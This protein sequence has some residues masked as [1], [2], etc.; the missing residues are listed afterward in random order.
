MFYIWKIMESLASTFIVMS[1]SYLASP[2]FA[3]YGAPTILAVLLPKLFM[4]SS[5]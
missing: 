1:D 2:V 4:A 3:Q 5:P